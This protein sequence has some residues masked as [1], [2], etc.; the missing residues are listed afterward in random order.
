MASVGMEF[1]SSLAGW[2]WLEVSMEVQSEIS[3]GCSHLTF[4]L[5]LEDLLPRGSLMGLAS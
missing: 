3:W 1:D 2:S 5:W 4:R